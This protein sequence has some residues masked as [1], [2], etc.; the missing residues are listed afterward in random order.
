[1]YLYCL[2]FTP[3]YICVIKNKCLG[4][5]C[6]RSVTMKA[7]WFNVVKNLS[8][9]WPMYGSVPWNLFSKAIRKLGRDLYH[10]YW[11]IDIANLVCLLT[12]SWDQITSKI[13]RHHVATR[14]KPRRKTTRTSRGILDP[15]W[16]SSWPNHNINTNWYFVYITM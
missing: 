2:H 14:S 6:W 12:T 13:W 3:S 10:W 9:K 11:S 15:G 5:C 4:T 7:L 1:M 8:S 16:A